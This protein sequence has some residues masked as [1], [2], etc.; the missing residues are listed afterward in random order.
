[1][2]SG[3]VFHKASA[4]G[5]NSVVCHVVPCYHEKWPYASLDFVIHEIF[6]STF[7][8]CKVSQLHGYGYAWPENSSL[9]FSHL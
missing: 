7:H 4:I 6:C 9:H 3:C 5:G 8:I 2:P 1:M